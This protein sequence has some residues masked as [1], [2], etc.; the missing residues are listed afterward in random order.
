[1]EAAVDWQ[2][3]RRLFDAVCDLPPS[4]WEESLRTLSNDPALIREALALLHAQT[5]GFDRALQPLRELMGTLST[6]ELQIGDR[7]G[8]WQL[9]QRLASGGMGTVYVAERADE[10]F[11]QRV[12][13]KLLRGGANSSATAQRLAAERQILAELQ[14]PNIAKL[15]DGGTTPAGQPY[16]VMEYIE[17]LPLDQYC[18]QR[19]LTL[20]ER[21]QLFLRVC[22]PVQAA[23]QR[24]IVHCDLKPSNVL[25]RDDGQPMLLDFGI[26]RLLGDGDAGAGFCTPAY[27]SPELLSG[28]RVG[29]ASDVFGLGVLLTEL[30]ACARSGRGPDD[31]ERP[32]PLPSELATADCAW[33]GRLTGDLD[34]IASKACAL[35]PERRYAT[36]EA[37]AADIHRHLAWKPVAA[38][39]STARY[40][41]WRWTRRHWRG[42]AIA[43]AAV[44][45]AV[46][47]VWRLSAERERAQ[48]E[49]RTAQR[50]SDFLVET[51]DAADPRMRGPKGTEEP[52]ARGLLDLAVAKVDTELAGS[53]AM[54]ARMRAVLG[55]AYANLGERKRAEEMLRQ[56][57]EALL[58]PP[59]SRPDL[60]AEAY[61]ELSNLMSN[62]LRAADAMEAAQRSLDLRLRH[63]ASPRALA[64]SYNA[65][66]LAQQ[67]A[68]DFANARTS[69]M[70]AL[71]LSR[72]AHGPESLEVA[73]VLHNTATLL[74]A[75]G[76]MGAAEASYRQALAIKLRHGENS[77][78][79]HNSRQGLATALNFMGR[80]EEAADLQRQNIR[81][82]EALVGRDSERVADAEMKLAL[83][84]QQ[85]GDYAGAGLHYREAMAVG[86]R[87]HGRGTLDYAV[88]AGQLATLEEARGDFAAAEKLYREAMEIRRANLP[89]GDRSRL[90]SDVFWAR[91]LMRMGRTE[92]AR[93]VMDEALPAWRAIYESNRASPEYVVARLI[94]TEWLMHQGR[95]DEAQAAVPVVVADTPAAVVRREVLLAELAQRG[96][97][98]QLAARLW[99][100]AVASSS[101]VVGA[102]R[103]PT[104]QWRVPFAESLVAAGRIREAGE[105]I[106][107]AEPVL[108][109]ALV[110]DAQMLKRLEALKAQLA[111]R[112]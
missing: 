33:R 30:L 34:A 46:L 61:S 87:V 39:T 5:A 1:M 108:R 86:I 20:H 103:P 69:L 112:G 97:D 63:D 18:T 14:H 80:F 6:D 92:E 83:V 79:V 7:L 76:D 71:V 81:L 90:R 44:I 111:V 3:L 70:Q 11:R 59:V 55:R 100:Q 26:A 50:V 93:P 45:V 48:E 110:G 57:A 107:R 73:S 12:A 77:V 109:K 101:A 49:A 98:P 25:V 68:A 56:A 72:E 67:S 75:M 36:V 53:P 42:S 89:V 40:R 4:Q 58:S 8:V 37:L 21:L 78:T 102:D 22:A 84:L 41:I 85:A 60:A 9:I 51:F 15:F 82:A 96:K 91:I 43:S 64:D 35:D 2:D 38:R 13:I 47:F 24:L 54:L 52:T 88:V 94:Q 99:Q 19:A 62:Q 31:S 28:A 105:Q 66:G 29:V 65:L 106:R 16:L 74:R 104:A 32:V 23:H 27:A 10:L 95:L 17:G